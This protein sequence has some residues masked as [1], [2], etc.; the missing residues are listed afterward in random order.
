MVGQW[1]RISQDSYCTLCHT[2]QAGRA[3]IAVPLFPNTTDA[4][5]CD[6]CSNEDLPTDNLR[7]TNGSHRL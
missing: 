7:E 2:E 3:E 1:Q 6:K 4:N 5:L